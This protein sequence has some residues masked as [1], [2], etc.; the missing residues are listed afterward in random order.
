VQT[1]PPPARTPE[2]G[3]RLVRLTR[4]ARAALV[5][6]DLD[7]ARSLTG[8]PLSPWFTSDDCTWLWR[9]RLA[10]AEQD[11]GSLEWVA[12]AAVVGP[13]DVVVGHAGFHGP[14]DATGM[15]EAG[16]SVDPAFRRRGHA[17]A[18]VRALLAWAATAEGVTR[19]R[20]S[21]SPDNEASL[22]TIRGFGFEAV[23]EQWDDEDGLEI[24]HEVPVRP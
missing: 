5:A 12:R 18:M 21:I 1:S 15:V 8:V 2:A 4:E 14:P 19:V 16:Y 22:A 9:I 17:R 23:G 11:P 10:Q 13:D 24:I 6:G 20:A 3:L 7:A